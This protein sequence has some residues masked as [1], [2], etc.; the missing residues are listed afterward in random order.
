[1]LN[2]AR[3]QGRSASE[4]DE[5]LSA[6]PEDSSEGNAKALRPQYDLVHETQTSTKRQQLVLE[7][8]SIISVITREQILFRN[9]RSVAEAL[10][11]LPG[12]FVSHDHG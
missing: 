9:Y 1:M 12:I 2:T 8:P 10:R 7:A 3:G 4:Q 6:N 5:T 11:S